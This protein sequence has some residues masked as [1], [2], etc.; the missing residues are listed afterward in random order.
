MV[1]CPR[2]SPHSIPAPLRLYIARDNDAAGRKAAQWLRE[3]GPRRRH[4]NP[5]P[6]AGPWRLQPR[7]LPSRPRPDAGP[8]RESAHP[9]LTAWISARCSAAPI[10]GGECVQRHFGSF[11]AAPE[12]RAAFRLRRRCASAGKEP[13]MRPSR[14]AIC[15]RRGRVAMAPAN[16]FPPPP[17]E[18]R[19]CSAKQNSCPA[20]SS[21]AL[22]PRKRPPHAAGR[23]GT[24]GGATRLRRRPRDRREGRDRRG[25]IL[26]PERHPPCQRHSYYPF[27][28]PTA[29]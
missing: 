19:L 20:P 25:S 3:R 12:G 13:R 21:A 28:S 23:V 17:K 15:R 26:R 7:S 5:R 24:P 16:Y 22:R 6:R 9:L 18:G 2:H 1:P 4:R 14:T 29:D 8:S 10:R 27:P 11:G